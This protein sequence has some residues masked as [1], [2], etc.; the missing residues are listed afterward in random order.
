MFDIPPSSSKTDAVA[1]AWRDT[2][3]RLAARNQFF[4]EC[5]H[6]P[7][8]EALIRWDGHE[9]W[10]SWRN[11]ANHLTCLLYA[12]HRACDAHL[13]L[14]VLLKHGLDVHAV[15]RTGRGALALAAAGSKAHR[16][17]W[18]K[19]LLEHGANPHATDKQ[20]NTPMG[21]VMLSGDLALLELM[22]QHDAKPSG[23]DWERLED[24]NHPQALVEF[25]QRF[26]PPET[27]ALRTQWCHRAARKGYWNQVRALLPYG[28][29]LN[30]VSD[31]ETLVTLAAARSKPPV[32]LIEEMIALGAD[33]HFQNPTTGRDAVAGARHANRLKPTKEV[34]AAEAVGGAI[35]AGRAR[36]MESALNPTQNAAPR[37]RQR[38]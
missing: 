21:A 1:L 36:R 27:Q 8:P 35:A 9:I 11:E 17:G 37:P 4:S 34:R 7:T 3:A 5:F 28:V 31:G 19:A 33:P 16:L 15:D 13:V 30:G 2:P 25:F 24:V 29:D 32:D 14:P 26:G 12:C 20:G 38:F 6:E 10:A 18:F 22:L 23:A